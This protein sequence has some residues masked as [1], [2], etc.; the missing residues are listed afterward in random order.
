MATNPNIDK[1]SD[2]YKKAKKDMEEAQKA[3]VD[4]D[5]TQES[6]QKT[7]QEGWN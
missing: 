2:Q 6:V 1:N 7:A 4:F 5:E 3:L